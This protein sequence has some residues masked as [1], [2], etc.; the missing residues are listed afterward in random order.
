MPPTGPR[1]QADLVGQRLLN[2]HLAG[3]PLA[4]PAEVVRHLGAVQSQDFPGALWAIAQRCGNPA[5]SEVA[6][7]LTSGAIIRTH[8]LRPTWH[9]VAPE[10]LRWMLAL[11]GPR[12]MSGS[13]GRHRELELDA[14]VFSRSRRALE[15]T[16]AGGVAATRAEVAAALETAGIA[17]DGQ[18]LVHILL[19]AEMGGVICSGPLVGKKQTHVLVEEWVAAAPVLAPDEA[20]VELAVRYFSSHGPALVSDFT[21]WSSLTVAQARRA[22]DGAAQRLVSVDVGGRTMWT[23]PTTPAGRVA[24]PLVRLLPNFDEY[25]VAYRDRTDFYDPALDPQTLRGGVMANIVAV[26]G[27]A[28]GNWTRRPKARSV[29]LAVQPWIAFTEAAWDAVETEADRLGRHLQLPVTLMR[30]RPTAR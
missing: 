18:R 17:I 16:L 10:D 24:S 23:S 9:F 4:G 2:Q 27:T 11:T 14:E 8:V 6:A 28:V 20:A 19:H 15:R 25:V 12:V 13:A 1:H 30:G 29:E 21:W 22:I 26:D 3:A 7:A 5:Q